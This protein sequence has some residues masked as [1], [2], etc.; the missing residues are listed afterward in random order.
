MGTVTEGEGGKENTDL[1]HIHK[2]KNKNFKPSE[3]FAPLALAMVL[4]CRFPLKRAR[5]VEKM[6]DS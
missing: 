5:A 1:I 3:F 4:K 2:M 6:A